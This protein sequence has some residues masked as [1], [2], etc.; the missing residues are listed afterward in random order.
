MIIT[1]LLLRINKHMECLVADATLVSKNSQ[2]HAAVNTQLTLTV[3]DNPALHAT[4]PRT[5]L[6]GQDAV[7][8]R[9]RQ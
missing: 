5:T 8:D 4:P 2:L 3:L 1:Y 9:R 7:T 6:I